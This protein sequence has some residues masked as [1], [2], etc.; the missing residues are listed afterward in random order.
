MRRLGRGIAIALASLGAV[1]ALGAGDAQEAPS[2]GGKEPTVV[3]TEAGDR[4]RGTEGRDLIWGG[5]GN[6]VILGLDGHDVICGGPGDDLIVGGLGVDLVYGETGDDTIHGGL[7]SD[8]LRGGRGDDT[9]YSER[10]NDGIRGGPGNDRLYGGHGDDQILGGA[11]QDFIHGG[12]GIDF[13]KGGRGNDTIDGGYGWDVMDGGP[14]EDTASFASAA[15]SKRRGGGVRVSLRTGRATGDGRDR[16]RRF[17]QVVGSAF[18][19]VLIGGRRRAGLYGGPGR[20]TL[21]GGGRNELHGGSGSDRCRGAPRRSRTGCGRQRMPKAP[22]HIHF[23]TDV[24]DPGAAGVLVATGRRNDDVSLAFD[25]EAGLL[26]IVAGSGIA[27]HGNCRRP[28]TALSEAVCPV[29]EAPRWVTVDLGPG[30][31]RFRG[32]GSLRGA[33]EVRVAGGRGDDLLRGGDEDS[34]LEGGPGSDR[35]HGGGGQD[36]LVA[37]HPGGP[38]FLYGGPGGNL[39]A[40]GP[41]CAGGRVVGGSGPDNVSFAE[42]PIQRGTLDASLRRGNAYVRGVRGCRPVRFA[43]EIENLEGSFGSDILEGDA[44]PNNLL[45]QPGRDRFFSGGGE[46]T[47]D[48][49]DGER[50]LIIDCGRG[51]SSGRALTDA[52]DPPTRRCATRTNGSPVPGLGHTR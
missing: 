5:P 20:D 44:G 32:I 40:A 47:I 19:D 17:Q 16:L 27:I 1:M 15:R 37:G 2:C 14:G 22:V 8:D 12:L 4:L 45:G 29:G 21:I 42:L 50:D 9:I 51:S 49:R 36:A 48:A 28:G 33:G 24:P 41:P 26:S 52:F 6:D 38:N 43:G 35:I 10:G 23:D 7:G 34:L 18:D 25:P 31:D 46:D 13:L 39:L 3:G 30:N 11:G